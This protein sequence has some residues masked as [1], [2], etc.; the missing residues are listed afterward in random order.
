MLTLHKSG[1]SR[2]EFNMQVN[3]QSM[4]KKFMVDTMGAIIF[5]VCNVERASLPSVP[6][7]VFAAYEEVARTFY[8]KIPCDKLTR[9][10]IIDRYDDLRATLGAAGAAEHYVREWCQSAVKPIIFA[11]VATATTTPAYAGVVVVPYNVT[12]TL[13]ER[14]V[15][16]LPGGGA[17]CCKGILSLPVSSPAQYD[18]CTTA[19]RALHTQ[20]WCETLCEF[21]QRLGDEIDYDCEF[22]GSVTLGTG[23]AVTAGEYARVESTIRKRC[24]S[25]AW[26]ALSDVMHLG[27]SVVGRAPAEVVTLWRDCM[28]N[29]DASKVARAALDQWTVVVVAEHLRAVTPEQSGSVVQLL[30]DAGHVPDY[31]IE[32][33]DELEVDVF[34]M[35]YDTVTRLHEMLAAPIPSF[36][37]ESIDFSD[38]DGAI[39]E[40]LSPIK[41]IVKPQRRRRRRSQVVGPTNYDELKALA[42]QTR[43]N[44]DAALRE[45]Q[46]E[47]RRM[48]GKVVSSD[49]TFA[50]EDNVAKYTLDEAVLIQE[51]MAGQSSS[52]STTS[53]EEEGEVREP[54]RKKQVTV[55]QLMIAAAAED[56]V[57]SFYDELKGATC[58]IH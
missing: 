18:E 42:K 32:M 28:S 4:A 53:E 19:V 5:K 14:H 30:A 2:T 25:G 7:G 20:A 41:P 39:A 29:N 9:G 23:Y 47:L 50:I 58:K 31:G 49:H 56:E 24:A 48:A 17:T 51:I 45:L 21:M 43:D 57:G 22:G 34:D 27:V 52:T 37:C 13:F 38:F 35:T 11:P 40:P 12:D 10:T 1:A 6:V 15:A 36:I 16:S 54:A 44:S 8:I 46:N 55:E 26:V 3:Y 33:P